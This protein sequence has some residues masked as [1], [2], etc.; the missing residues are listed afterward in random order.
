MDGNLLQGGR[1]VAICDRVRTLGF[2][3][4][5]RQ[6][7]KGKEWNSLEGG[8]RNLLPSRVEIQ[9]KLEDSRGRVHE[10]RTQTYLPMSG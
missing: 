7:G 8:Q 6:G 1:S 2:S 3:Y 9:L 10:F 4:Y 5:D